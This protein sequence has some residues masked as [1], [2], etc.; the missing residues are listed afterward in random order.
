MEF[1]WDHKKASSNLRKHKVSFEEATTVFYD[2][3]SATFDDPDHST[4]EERLI[5]I[6]YSSRSRLLV[7]SHTERG[8]TI[9]IIS[10]RTATAHERKR[11]ES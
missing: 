8:K 5:T 11:H 9:R 10:A 6:G 4:D 7:V 3:L 2:S 1:E